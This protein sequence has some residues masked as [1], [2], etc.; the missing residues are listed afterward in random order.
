[1]SRLV[2]DVQA[3]HPNIP[4]TELL[5]AVE[6]LEGLGLLDD[7]SLMSKSLSTY[8][9][10]LYDR[11]MLYFSAVE[12][13]GRPAFEYQERLKSQHATVF[14]LGGWGTWITLNLALSGFGHLCLVDG[15]TVDVSNLNRQVLY[16]QADLGKLKALAAAERVAVINPY[17]AATPKSVFVRKDKAQVESLISPETTVVFL[18]WANMGYYR[19]GTCEELIHAA[20]AERKIPV[21]EMG[22]DPMD[23]SVGPIFLN[24]G[25]SATFLESRTRQRENFLGSAETPVSNADLKT[26]RIMGKFSDGSRVVNAWQNASSISAMA[27]LAVGEAIKVLTGCE[28][29]RLIGRRFVLSLTDFNSQL[30]SLGTMNGTEVHRR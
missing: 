22:G 10:A 3:V 8:E 18:A 1:M 29:S 2:K 11:Q 25:A 20:C 19:N 28:T 7:A 26:A 30:E 6:F 13:A 27:G 4:E 5:A 15:D 17:V 9:L 21:I 23:I 16:E 12:K 14:G 24:D